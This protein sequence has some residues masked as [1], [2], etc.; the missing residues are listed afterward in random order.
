MIVNGH[1]LPLALV[2]AIQNRR[3]RRDR[4]SWPL[5]EE[6][7]AYGNH[8]ESELGEVFDTLSKLTDETNALPKGFKS[9]GC[10]GE[11]NSELQ[12]LG[13]IPD[14]LDFKDI[15][16]FAMAADGSPFCLDYRDKPERPSVIWWDDVYWRRVAPD[17]ESFLAL[18]DFN[19][20]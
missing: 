8:F 17:F 9:D 16:C 19:V 1:E 2:Q 10:Y 13:A 4:G 7:D 5:L 18:F 11:S 6:H 15:I 20:D 3:L 14:I 12:G